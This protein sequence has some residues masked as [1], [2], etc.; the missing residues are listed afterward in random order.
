MTSVDNFRG[1]IN[2]IL[3]AAAEEIFRCFRN[4]VVDEIDRLRRTEDLVSKPEEIVY[5]T[6]LYIRQIPP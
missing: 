5:N 1:F 4:A 2:E 6:G 3:N